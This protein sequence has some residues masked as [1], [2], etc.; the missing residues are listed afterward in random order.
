MMSAFAIAAKRLVAAFAVGVLVSG[1]VRAR[2][3]DT[4][5]S[6][7]VEGVKLYLANHP[8][9]ALEKF[10]EVLAEN[11]GN[12]EALRFLEQGGREVFFLML[13]REGEYEAT[14]KRFLELARVARKEKV[15]DPAAIDAL[16][17]QAM[18]GDYLERRDALQELSADHGEY[19]AAPFIAF[20]G[21]EDDS[22]ARVAAIFC[23]TSLSGDS[24]LPLIAALQ[25]DNERLVWNAAAALGAIGDSRAVPALKRVYE[26]TG[27][28]TVRA[29]ASDALEK[30][31]GEP[32]AALPT[33]TELHVAMARDYFRNSPDVVSPFDTQEAVWHF[34]DGEVALEEVPALL[35]HLKLAEQNCFAALESDQAKAILYA[36]YA[37]EIASLREGLAMGLDV[38]S[39]TVD[40]TA[41][42]LGV[43]LA[44]GGPNGLSK[45]LSFAL[46]QDAPLTA[47]ELIDA[48]RDVGYATPALNDALASPYASVRYA[49]AF[50][51]AENGAMNDQVVR[52]LVEALG[53]DPVPT[54]LIVDDQDE[55][56]NRLAAV[57]EAGGMN[58]IT[59]DRGGIGFARARTLPAKDVLIVR[60]GLA[61]V[62]LDQ[63]VYDNDFRIADTPLLVLT[64]DAS[65]ESIESLYGGQVAGV[66]LDTATETAVEEVRAVLG[67]MNREREE[68]L[69]AASRAAAILAHTSAEQLRPAEAG[70]VAA[71]DRSDEGVLVSVLRAVG[72]LGPASAAPAVGAIFAETSNPAAVRV[73]AADALCGIFANMTASP[74]A[75]VVDPVVA[76][77][78]ADEDVEVRLAAGRALG[79]A[80]FLDGEQRAQFLRDQ[81]TL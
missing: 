14:A 62:T 15:N 56:R 43:A 66:L 61:D 18:G 67:E 57:L 73:A 27:S 58:V 33:S 24:V 30:I 59:A 31:T 64:D 44:A 53:E 29:A 21:N 78:L 52:V 54:V 25:S 68:A 13:L 16:V 22:E 9:E 49:A 75:D 80:A 50:A 26:V 74:G 37:G 48:L 11:P 7:F 39:A 34:S 8:E 3:D 47:V 32:A 17:A 81:R 38:D 4:E 28:E 46:E 77:A 42:R 55:A 65:R 19:G 40:E 20:L 70:L 45:A 71:L 23:L 36:S 76:A 41:A 63:F 79:C 2:Q 6:T 51:L 12:E 72:R 1:T 5:D 35:R 60:A 10:Q 69:A